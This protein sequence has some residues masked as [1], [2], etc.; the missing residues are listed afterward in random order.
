MD[1]TGSGTADVNLSVTPWP[2]T[3][4]APSTSH[5]C[6]F[7]KV[8]TSWGLG[9]LIGNVNTGNSLVVQW[10]GPTIFNARA[11]VQS[12]VKELRFW[13]P[14]GTVP[15]TPSPPPPNEYNKNTYLI[16]STWHR[17]K[18]WIK[19][20][21]TQTVVSG[22]LGLP[23]EWTRDSPSVGRVNRHS[24]CQGWR[25]N[26][27]GVRNHIPVPHFILAPP[28]DRLAFPKEVPGNTTPR[29]HFF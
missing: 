23:G 8:L 24:P 20:P 29:K 28:Q 26:R 9:F 3:S 17:K 12:L 5:L 2:S 7:T 27:C 22:V 6:D 19:S 10:L 15:R 13:K 1:S 4:H 16:N 18:H 11:Q 21:M 14:C 25:G